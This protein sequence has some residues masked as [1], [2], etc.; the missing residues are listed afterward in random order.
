MTY[1]TKKQII[2]KHN[3][4]FQGDNL[5]SLTLMVEHG[6]EVLSDNNALELLEKL[7]TTWCAKNA[8]KLAKLFTI[9]GRQKNGNVRKMPHI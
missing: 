3:F 9:I 5:I 8:K 2:N 7:P 6:L 4:Y 1:E